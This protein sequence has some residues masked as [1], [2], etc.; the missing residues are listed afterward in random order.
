MR[1]GQTDWNKEGRIQGH[2]DIPLNTVGQ[3]QALQVQK[4]IDTLPHIKQIF[5]SPLQRAQE[6]MHISCQNLNVPKRALPELKERHRG[7][8]E[9]MTPD[10][11]LLINV[12]DNDPSFG[13]TTTEYHDQVLRGINHALSHD[14]PVLIVAHGGTYYALCY[15]MGIEV[16]K[17]ANCKLVLCTPSTI[18]ACWSI[19]HI[20]I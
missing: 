17:F 18:D 15:F 8:L 13:E 11:Y 1:H 9:G 20:N 12:N 16:E 10:Q 6:T 2:T 7:H 14:D 19:Q 5:Y 3:E 4:H